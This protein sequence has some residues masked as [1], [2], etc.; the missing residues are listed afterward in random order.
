MQLKSHSVG[1]LLPTWH[2]KKGKENKHLSPANSRPLPLRQKLTVLF[3][4]FVTAVST[5][6]ETDTKSD[7][8][9][10][11]PLS[12]GNARNEHGRIEPCPHLISPHLTKTSR[13]RDP[14]HRRAPT[15]TIP[16]PST[17]G[18]SKQTCEARTTKGK[19]LRRAYIEPHPRK[20]MHGRVG[21]R[22]PED[23]RISSA[24]GAEAGRR[25]GSGGG[26]TVRE[27]GRARGCE[28]VL[29]GWVYIY[30]PLCAN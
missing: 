9:K 4:Q 19:R 27:T 10:S 24:G 13:R 28:S 16:A 25:A 3:W 8:K 21:R 26:A 14:G 18:G 22:S 2:P 20:K 12:H 11:V 30:M 23:G 1:L 6:P 5:L 15:A 17:R 7:K 29:D